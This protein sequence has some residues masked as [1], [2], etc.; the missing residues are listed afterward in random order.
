MYQSE[1]EERE[2]ILEERELEVTEREQRLEL[3]QASVDKAKEVMS[4]LQGVEVKVEEKFHL[5]RE[6][7]NFETVN[8]GV[9]VQTG[10]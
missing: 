10:F 1:L 6:V 8:F 4:R 5:L 7:K 3:N 9:V 2:E